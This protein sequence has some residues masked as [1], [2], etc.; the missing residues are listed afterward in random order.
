MDR[1]RDKLG[2][3]FG[4][5]MW[6]QET[7]GA[8]VQLSRRKL[9]EELRELAARPSGLDPLVGGILREMEYVHAV[10]VHRGVAGRDVQLSRVDLG[11]L[12]DDR[13]RC[14]M[15]LT[16]VAGEI[17]KKHCIAQLGEMEL[18]HGSPVNGVG[19]GSARE[20]AMTSRGTVTISRDPE[21]HLPDA[22][23][24]RA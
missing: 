8:Q 22:A 23:S 13:C 17:S 10:G 11:D 18:V 24:V 19:N 9:L 3:I 20:G 2:G 6:R 12:R 1:C 5:Q 21:G 14:H 16:V 7:D 4:S 15:L